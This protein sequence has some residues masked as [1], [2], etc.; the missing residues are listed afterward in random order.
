MKTNRKLLIAV[1]LVAVL[2]GIGLT[3]RLVRA[4]PAG[5]SRLLYSFVTNQVGFDTGLIIAN[6]SA[7]PFGTPP[8][9]GGCKLFFFGA[10]APAP[11]TT[12]VIAAGQNF[13]TLTSVIAPNFQGYVIAGCNFPLAHGFYFEGTVGG[14]QYVGASQALV[15][16]VPRTSPEGL[17]N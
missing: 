7:D 16:T 15:L 6:T 14:G 9:A 12:P 11:F 13:T 8:V 2:G 4:Q 17:N 10:N 5:T 3:S 1:S